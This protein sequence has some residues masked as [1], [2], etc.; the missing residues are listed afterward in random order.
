MNKYEYVT[1]KYSRGFFSDTLT[2]HRNVIEMYS[3]R[4]YKY[5]GWIPTK[6]Y[7]YGVIT[8]VDLIFELVD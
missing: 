7:G 1:V 4:G 8:E 5:V 6:I 3:W 2:E